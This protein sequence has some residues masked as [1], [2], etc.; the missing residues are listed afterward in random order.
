MPYPSLPSKPPA[1]APWTALGDAVHAAI[2]QAI[3]DLPGIR[4]D[5]S[6]VKTGANTAVAGLAS[7]ASP[8]FTGTVTGITKGMVGL[9]NVDNTPDSARTIT[10]GQITSGTL[11]PAR[12]PA[13]CFGVRRR[14]AADEAAP[15]ASNWQPR[16]V[17]YPAVL[18]VGALPAPSDAS[19]DDLHIAPAS[20]VTDAAA[21]VALNDGS[22]IPVWQGSTTFNSAALV[23][24]VQVTGASAT[25]RDAYLSVFPT[26]KHLAGFRQIAANIC[27]LLYASPA[28]VPYSV[29]T[30]TLDFSGAAGVLA[31]TW[32][33]EARVEFG[34]GSVGA[35]V[36]A[37]YTTHEMVHLFGNGAP[38]GASAQAR[39][40]IEGIADWVL[41]QLGYHT[42]ANQR[43]SG[44]GTSWYAGYDTTAFFLDYVEKHAPTPTPG[45]VR[46]LNATLTGPT[47]DPAVIT[48]INARRL[49]VEQLWAEYKAWL[50]PAPTP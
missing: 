18:N 15:T 45:F 16:P 50:A 41:I 1:G 10:A 46:A 37:S 33:S 17:G 40:V 25:T 32:R 43:P 44:G 3:T 8:T 36:T 9:G 27:A 28:D 48:G 22:V 12:L 47:W 6:A 2:A 13:G 21:P 39:G 30:L 42:A 11:A 26:T 29:P 23:G 35:S 5:L 20:A 19:A 34:S 38:Y 31:Q 24:S 14:A 4:T 49:T 7:S